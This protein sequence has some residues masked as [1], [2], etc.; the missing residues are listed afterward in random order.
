MRVTI[1]LFAA[2]TAAL[3]VPV[4]AKSRRPVEAPDTEA[5]QPSGAAPDFAEYDNGYGFAPVFEPDVDRWKRSWSAE[6]TPAELR[7]PAG[8]TAKALGLFKKLSPKRQP[9]EEL[10]SYWSFAEPSFT[11]PWLDQSAPAAIDAAW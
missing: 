8:T 5:E 9:T 6:P 2:I 11:P 1:F 4:M 7:E 3:T 10:P